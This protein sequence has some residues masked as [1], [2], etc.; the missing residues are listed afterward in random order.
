MAQCLNVSDCPDSISPLGRAHA[1]NYAAAFTSLSGLEPVIPS[2]TWAIQLTAVLLISVVWLS[3]Q[4]QTRR[5]SKSLSALPESKDPPRVPYFVP[6]LGHV[7]SYLLDPFG[8]ASFIRCVIPARSFFS[9]HLRAQT[10]Q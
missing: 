10:D 9:R 3:T 7:F 5:A 2:R 8:L 6:V 4:M 1:E